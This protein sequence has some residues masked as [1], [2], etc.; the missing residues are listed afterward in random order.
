MSEELTAV[1]MVLADVEGPS[2]QAWSE[3]R[4]A[5]MAEIEGVSRSGALTRR[6]RRW[7]PAMGVVSALAVAGAVVL[8]TQVFV[9]GGVGRPSFAAAAVLRRAADAALASPPARLK[10]GEYWYTENEGT[11]LDTGSIRG[12]TVSAFVSDVIQ[13]WI[14][15]HNGL[16]RNH[17]VRVVPEPGSDAAQRRAIRSQ[18]PLRTY[19]SRHGNPQATDVPVSYSRMLRAPRSTAALA[20]WVLHAEAAP[21]FTPK[22]RIRPQAMFTTIHDILIEPMVPA[23]LQAGL[24]RVAATIPGVHMLGIR[25]DT[26][27]R[28]GLAVGFVDPRSGYEDELLFDPRSYALLDYEETTR[29]RSGRLPAGTVT[30]ETAFLAAGIV[31]RIGQTIPR[32]R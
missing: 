9:R 21:G 5:L 29:H 16:F 17:D 1:R 31:H 4:A 2:D 28:A 30:E 6:R 24:F 23:R 32:G 7:V 15:R 14:G 19:S 8:A 22:P 3:A 27:G 25:H 13:L 11:Y 20:T 10:P 26:L 12:G 18:F